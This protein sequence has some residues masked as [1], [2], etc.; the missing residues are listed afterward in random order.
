MFAG[1]QGRIVQ[2]EQ[3]ASSGGRRITRQHKS[4]G[5]S[6]KPNSLMGF[7]LGMKSWITNMG[8]SWEG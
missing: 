1:I 4:S 2:S 7:Q 5:V 3:K 6:M 8:S